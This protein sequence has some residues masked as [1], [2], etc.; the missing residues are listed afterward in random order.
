VKFGRIEGE[1]KKV[2]ER[3]DY[4]IIEDIL[5]RNAQINREGDSGAKRI[6]TNDTLTRAL[7]CG[8]TR[9]REC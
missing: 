7:V 4:Q 3:K 9:Q 6:L 5:K 8:C 1:M 2:R